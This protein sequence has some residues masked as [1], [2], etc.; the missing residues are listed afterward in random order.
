MS[1]PAPDPAAL[2]GPIV[3]GVDGS[4]DAARSLAVAA[5]LGVALGARVQVVHALGLMT[6]V[7]GRHVPAR[8]HR[9]EVESMVRGDWCAALAVMDGLD[10][11]AEVRDGTPSE[12]LVHTAVERDASMI[13]VGA[14]GVGG[15]GVLGSTSHHVVHHAPCPTV[16]VPATAE[17]R[18]RQRG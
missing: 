10:W 18:L 16:V 3:V 8:D 17:S 4:A 5:Q 2:A 12:V 13:V 9:A 11:E 14:R 1:A 15:A 7:D 6:V